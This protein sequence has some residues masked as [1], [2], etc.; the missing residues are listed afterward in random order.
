MFPSSVNMMR[1][2]FLLLT[3]SCVPLLGQAVKVILENVFHIIDKSIFRIAMTGFSTLEEKPIIAM[4]AAKD[5][6]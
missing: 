5:T 1:S 2:Y 6:L 3:I 4:A